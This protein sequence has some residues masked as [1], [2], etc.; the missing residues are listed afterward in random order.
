MVPT[1]SVMHLNHT[2]SSDL[3]SEEESDRRILIVDDEEPIRTLFARCL[4]DRYS[5]VT[6]AGSQEALL[7]L[8][9][10]T[11]ALVISDVQMPGLSGVELLRRIT[12]N[13]P[14]TAVIMVS[15]VD[16]TQRVLDTI[17][18]GAFDY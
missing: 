8:A 10:E 17:R 3:V 1:T 5:C 14:E 15:G 16:R 11:I 7:L 9:S 2:L 12:A 6:A 18:L 13:F 4:G